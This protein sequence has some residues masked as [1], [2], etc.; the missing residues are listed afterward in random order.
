MVKVISVSDETYAL[1]KSIKGQK[2]SFSEVIKEAIYKNRQD[3]VAIM[4]FFGA[5]KGKIDAKR[6]KSQLYKERARKWG[7]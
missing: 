1:L 6:W 4:G 3:N 5:L 2:M 7:D